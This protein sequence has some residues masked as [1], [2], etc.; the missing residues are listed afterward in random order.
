MKVFPKLLFMVAVGIAACAAYFSVKGIALLF[1]GSFYPVVVMASALEV[2]KIFAV[3]FLYRKWKE[4]TLLFKT[5]LLLAVTVLVIITSLGIFGFLSD[6]YQDTKTKVDYY[7]NQITMLSKQ[8]EDIKTREANS[9]R[10]AEMAVDTSSETAERYKSIYDNFAKQQTESKDKL[11]SRRGELDKELND[12]R[13]SSGGLF[14]SKKK[15]IEAMELA[16]AEERESIQSRLVSIDGAIDKEYTSFLTKVDQLTEPT[17]K[18]VVIDNNNSE[19]IKTNELEILELQSNI[20]DT[21]IGSFRYIAS[22]FDI[23]VDEAVKWFMFMI[24]FVFDP[25]AM[26]LVLGYNMYVVRRSRS[27]FRP[28]TRDEFKDLVRDTETVI[29]TQFEEPEDVPLSVDVD[30]GSCTAKK[31]VYIRGKKQR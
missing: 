9:R 12:L 10:V 23:S 15:K 2:G 7:E 20:N 14:S 6:A 31:V 8:N 24:V 17:N 1:A 16:Q 22:A 3:S 11:I 27:G 26:S 25:L 21:D 18:P 5:Y 29:P 19:Q 13:A 4:I 28:K 30:D